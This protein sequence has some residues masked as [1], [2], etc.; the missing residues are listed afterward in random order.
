MVFLLPIA[1]KYF[2]KN[3]IISSFSFISICIMSIYILINRKYLIFN[4]GKLINPNKNLIY[5]H[6]I[7]LILFYI[8]GVYKNTINLKTMIILIILILFPLSFP[9]EYYFI[10][11]TIS[12]QLLSNLNYKYK[13]W[14]L[15]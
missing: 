15:I 3:L 2:H 1:L 8:L 10:Y 12:L 14:E 5:N 13:L 4:K 7:I 11:R 9:I 6:I